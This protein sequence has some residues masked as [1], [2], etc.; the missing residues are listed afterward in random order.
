MFE[1]G[2]LFVLA[3]VLE[4]LEKKQ[5]KQACLPVKLQLPIVTDNMDW[6]GIQRLGTLRHL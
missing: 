5:K 1:F 6:L 4:K 2:F 3:C